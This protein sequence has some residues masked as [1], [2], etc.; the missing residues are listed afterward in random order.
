MDAPAIRMTAY[1]VHRSTAS[2]AHRVMLGLLFGD[3][4]DSRAASNAVRQFLTEST[5]FTSEVA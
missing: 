4:E 5:E 3:D 1:V 2:D